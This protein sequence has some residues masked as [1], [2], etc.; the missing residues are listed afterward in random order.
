[1]VAYSPNKHADVVTER[2]EDNMDRPIICGVDGSQDSRLALRVAADLAGR[3]G[4]RLIVVNVVAAPQDPVI[5][6]LAY[7][8]MA[9]PVGPMPPMTERRTDFDVGAAEAMLERIVAEEGLLDAELR[10]IVGHPAERLADLAD[11]EGVEL[12]V[13][14]S[15]GRGAFKAAFLGSVSNSLIGVARCPVLVVPRGAAEYAA[16]E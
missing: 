16:T 15:R 13:V 5:P 6:T 9:R 1:M 8:P 4:A 14:G 3:F 11:D 7:A 10:T 2:K 12:I